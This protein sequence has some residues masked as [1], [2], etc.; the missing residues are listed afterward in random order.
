[1]AA[2]L[3][4]VN[5]DADDLMSMGANNPLTQMPERSANR[6]AYWTLR[7]VGTA[8]KGSV[9]WGSPRYINAR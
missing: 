6:P 5:F 1:M 3:A 7:P 2:D 9:E 4:S 8:C